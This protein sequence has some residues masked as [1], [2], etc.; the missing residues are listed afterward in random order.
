[1]KNQGGKPEHHH[2]STANAEHQNLSMKMNMLRFA[3]LT[4][5][6]QKARELRVCCCPAL[7]VLKFL[8]HPTHTKADTS[9]GSWN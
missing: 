3:Y 5:Y 6:F 8:S 9:Y 4:K 2:G 7:Y 1:M